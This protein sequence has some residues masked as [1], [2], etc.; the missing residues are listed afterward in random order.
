M[1]LSEHFRE[2]LELAVA[3]GLVGIWVV[4]RIV[5]GRR[6]SPAELER[7]RRLELHRR[8]RIISGQIVDL[9]EPQPAKRGARLVVYKYEVAGVTY[10]ASQDISALPNVISTVRR[11]TGQTV[12]LKYEPRRPA[13]SILVCEEWSGLPEIGPTSDLKEQSIQA[14]Q[15]TVGGS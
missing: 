10:E 14:G 8:G 4:I 11:A 7:L 2:F 12:S 1:N 3:A 6:K 13:N 9:I 5:R 15:E